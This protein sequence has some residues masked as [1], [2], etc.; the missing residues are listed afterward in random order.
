MTS[1]LMIAR[2]SVRALLHRRLLLALMVVMLILT[3][4]FSIVLSQINSRIFDSASAPPPPAAAAVEQ[5]P[6]APG[7]DP[8]SFQDALKRAAPPPE[9]VPTEPM[10]QEM[11]AAGAQMLS[12]FYGFTAFGGMIVA[13]FIG[14]TAVSSDVRSGAITMILAR[15]VT[16]WQFLAGKFGGAMMVLFGYSLLTAIALVIFTQVHELDVVPALRYAP[17]L[18]FCRNLIFASFALALS[19][20]MPPILAGILPVFVSGDLFFGLLSSS[21][22]IH[23]L[24]FLLPTYGPFNAT[25]QFTSG[26]LMGWDEVAILTVYALDLAVIFCL[27]AMWRF[28]SK[29]VV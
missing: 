20:L 29:A 1:I 13:L 2:D 12:Q 9:P 5:E 27:L 28:R 6:A 25:N 7:E 10:L 15:P 4:I 19:M 16:R 14:A 23:Y 3:V 11:Q 26:V 8:Q 17:W 18:M 22:P 21:N 24:H